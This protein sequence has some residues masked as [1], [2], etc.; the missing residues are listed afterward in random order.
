MAVYDIFYDCFMFPFAFSDR[1]YAVS[2]S[3][4]QKSM[5]F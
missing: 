1:F 3:V 4:F 5:L 2:R